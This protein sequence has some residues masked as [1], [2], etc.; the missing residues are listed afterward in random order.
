MPGA[1]AFEIAAHDELNKY[2][3][4]VKGRARLGDEILIA[5]FLWVAD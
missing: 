4:Q 1:G 2:K 5:M 3:I